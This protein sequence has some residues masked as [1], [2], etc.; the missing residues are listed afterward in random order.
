MKHM[1]IDEETLKI[2]DEK[3]TYTI[4]QKVTPENSRIPHQQTRT[5][6]PNRAEATVASVYNVQID[7]P[8]GPT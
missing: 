1:H 4:S 8:D 6:C 5:D 3:V 2:W 7:R